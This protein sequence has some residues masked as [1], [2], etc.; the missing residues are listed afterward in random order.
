MVEFKDVMRVLGS[1]GN[2]ND[3]VLMNKRGKPSKFLGEVVSSVGGKEV[4]FGLLH[5]PWKKPVGVNKINQALHY[6]NHTNVDGAIIVGSKFTSSAIEQA[7]RN[8][9]ATDKRILLLDN[10]EI[11]AAN[12]LING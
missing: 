6:V 7:F 11:N 12:D 3:D 10:D 2:V 9:A 5:Y 4:K 1:L 8:N